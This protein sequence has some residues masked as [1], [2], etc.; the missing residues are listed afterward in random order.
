M[1]PRFW[2]ALVELFHK[3][4]PQEP[5]PQP[6]TQDD[7]QLVR[8]EEP[9]ARGGPSPSEVSSLWRRIN[10]DLL[11]IADTP[12]FPSLI[13]S[14]FINATASMRLLVSK[15]KQYADWVKQN[16]RQAAVIAACIIIPIILTATTPLILGAIGFSATGPLAGI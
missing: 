8:G 9:S 7:D 13:D 10:E 5:N 15:F 11:L 12:Q 4:T 14:A 16:P 2:T 6:S 3:S 1:A